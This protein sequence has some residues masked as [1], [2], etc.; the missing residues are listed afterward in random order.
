M[1]SHTNRKGFGQ[2][3][4]RRTWHET[5]E[6]GKVNLFKFIY[7]FQVTLER[8]VLQ[9]CQDF[10]LSRRKVRSE[11]CFYGK[12]LA[13]IRW[14]RLAAMKPDAGVSP[15]SLSSPQEGHHS[16]LAAVVLV[17][18]PWKVQVM[19]TGVSE[20]HLDF[21][22]GSWHRPPQSLGIFWVTRVYFVLHKK[23]PLSPSEFMLIRWLNVGLLGS[24]RWDWSPARPRD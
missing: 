18:L 4:E 1:V 21:L 13:E 9:W 11:M 20:V 16:L 14:E 7:L 6:H 10:I 8:Q 12:S 24:L 15:R 23:P 2:A 22:P 5:G 3:W 19:P 17:H